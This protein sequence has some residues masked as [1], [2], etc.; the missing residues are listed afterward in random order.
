MKPFIGAVPTGVPMM[1]LF[2]RLATRLRH[3][4]PFR[5]E[6]ALPHR[7]S[8]RR[9]FAEIA[10]SRLKPDEG[11]WLLARAVSLRAF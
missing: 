4:T 3:L 7:S 5:T 11:T 8:G 2:A 9:S 1:R 10:R 6:P